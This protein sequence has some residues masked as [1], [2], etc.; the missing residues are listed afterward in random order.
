MGPAP[1]LDVASARRYCAARASGHYENFPVLAAPFSRAQREALAAIYAFARTADDFADEPAFEGRRE[2]LLDGWEAE[3]RRCF[4]GDAE[5]P[6]FVALRDSAARFGYDVGPFLD[7]LSAFRQDVRVRR[8]AT[9]AELHDYCRRSANPV[10]RLVLQTL[11]ID[12]PRRRDG[13]DRLC[14][15]LQLANFWQD[16]SV[17]LPRDRLYVP[18]EDLER[19]GVPPA[20]LLAQRAT[21]GCAELLRLELDRTATLFAQSAP[22]VTRAGWPGSPYLAGVWLG[23]RTVLALTRALGTDVLRHRP[24]LGAGACL[25]WVGRALRRRLEREPS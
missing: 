8:Y 3:L 19:C 12:D 15:A 10:G 5:H 24:A 13:S 17:D 4:A 18:L 11:G 2:R 16:L 7:L 6:V 22:L 23:G 1:G 9:F 21:P 20:E 14:T 25:H